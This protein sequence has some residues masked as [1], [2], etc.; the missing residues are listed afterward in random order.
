LAYFRKIVL[1]Q[2]DINVQTDIR[3]CRTKTRD[4]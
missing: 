2:G 4:R 1:K 3:Q